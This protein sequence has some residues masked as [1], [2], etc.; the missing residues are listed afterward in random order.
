MFWR[1]WKRTVKLIE[2]TETGVRIA[3]NKKLLIIGLAVSLVFLVTACGN[4]TSG[5]SSQNKAAMNTIQLYDYSDRESD[6]M[7]VVAPDSGNS[8]VQFAV[9]DTYKE[10]F[11]AYDYYEKGKLVAPKCA[12][13]NMQFSYDAGPSETNGMI[14]TFIDGDDVVANIL[15]K[16]HNLAETNSVGSKSPLSNDD[17][18]LEDMSSRT[19]SILEDP[20]NIE[21]N[22]KIYLWAAIGTNDDKM[23]VCNDVST[24]LDDKAFKSY[25]KCFL[26]YA[27]FK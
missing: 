20:V 17:Q 26:F 25:D 2:T 7:S 9:D 19:E 13:S 11:V 14:Y 24:I 3:M 18:T 21:K 23:V 27:I 1:N 6:L 8:V 22:K 4:D 5:S 10:V 12:D 16:G 15:G